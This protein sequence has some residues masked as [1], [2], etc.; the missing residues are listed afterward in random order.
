MKKKNKPKLL[1]QSFTPGIKPKQNKNKINKNQKILHPS[2]GDVV[3]WDCF[4]LLEPEYKAWTQSTYF[5]G[6][7]TTEGS[8]PLTDI[9]GELLLIPESLQ[10]VLN[11]D[12]SVIQW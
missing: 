11:S 3:E 2:F 10:G 5:G 4:F 12:V 8:A 7:C 6:R 9:S 1:R